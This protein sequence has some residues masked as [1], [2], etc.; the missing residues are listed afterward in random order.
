MHDFLLTFPW[1]ITIVLMVSLL[2]AELLVPFLQFHFIRKP[3]DSE[4]PQKGKK[5]FSFLDVLQKYSDQ[6]VNFCFRHP[7]GTVATGIISVVLGVLLFNYIPQRDMPYAD[8][9]QFAVE[10]FLPTGTSLPKTGKIADSL[11]YI[12]KKDKHTVSVAVFKG[13]SSPRFQTTY[14]PQIGGT[15]FAQLIVNTSGPE[16]TTKMIADYRDKYVDYFPSAYVKFKQ[17]D[18]GTE[19]N[20]I[21]IRL[22]GSDWRLLKRNADSLTQRL[23][24][25]PELLLVRNDVYEPQLLDRIHLKEDEAGRMGVENS[26][27]E[28]IMALRYNSDGYQVGSVWN[29]DHEMPVRIKSNKGDRSTVQDILDEMVPA[30]GG[31]TCKGKH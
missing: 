5:K 15:N 27:L 25:M 19:A 29:G 14:A 6:L 9:N 8:R 18:Y 12:L 1:S 31:Q 4:L 22:S 13:C 28:N 23:R 2:V 17:L 7:Y 11:A 3:I 26:M 21:E 10:I 24:L 16:A 20:T 30:N